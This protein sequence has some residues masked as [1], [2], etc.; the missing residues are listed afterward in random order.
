M[1]DEGGLKAVVKKILLEP[2]KSGDPD[3]IADAMNIFMQDYIIKY[4]KDDLLREHYS[5]DLFNN[6][7]S[8]PIIVYN[9]TN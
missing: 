4:I 8:K 1:K 5:L 7:L 9:T 3:R 6:H 2:W